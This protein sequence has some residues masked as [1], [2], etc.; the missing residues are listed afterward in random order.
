MHNRRICPSLRGVLV[1]LVAVVLLTVVP[2]GLAM[3]RLAARSDEA[4]AL[5]LANF[6]ATS[7]QGEQNAASA[8]AIDPLPFTR[9]RGARRATG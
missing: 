8:H 4:D 6:L 1:V 5:A 7:N 3:S 9:P 2:L